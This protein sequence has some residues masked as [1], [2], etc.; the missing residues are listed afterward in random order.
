MFQTLTLN[1]FYK[2][3][4][5]TYLTRICFQVWLKMGFDFHSYFDFIHIFKVQMQKPLSAIWNFL[6]EWSFFYQACIF[7]FMCVCVCMYV[8]C[9]FNF[10]LSDSPEWKGHYYAYLCLSGESYLII[11]DEGWPVHAHSHIALANNKM[12]FTI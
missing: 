6:L 8:Y 4:H 10:F 2:M 3:A 7:K 1:Q 9:P 5:I 11:H 12:F